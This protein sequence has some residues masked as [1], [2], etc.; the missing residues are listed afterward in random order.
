MVES[1]ETLDDLLQGNVSE[2]VGESSEKIATRVKIAHDKIIA[3]YKQEDNAKQFD[4]SLVQVIK[5]LPLSLLEIVI[6]CL[7]YEIPSL[8]ILAIIS[9]SNEQSYGI[10]SNQFMQYVKETANFAEANF[11]DHEQEQQ[12]SYW[13]TFMFAS[14]IVSDTLKLKDLHN[15]HEFVREFDGYI[16]YLLEIFLKKTQNNIETSYQYD[17]VG[18]RKCIDNYKQQLF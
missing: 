11:K 8:T 17:E 9:I 6:L 18:L 1:I 5:S 7:N 13:W 12:M 14:N 2:L 10:C 16:D 4:Q 3:I 15:T